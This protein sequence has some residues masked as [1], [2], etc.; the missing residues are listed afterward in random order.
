MLPSSYFGIQAPF[1]L[2]YLFYYIR[3]A[4]KH[5]REH[6]TNFEKQKMFHVKHHA[7]FTLYDS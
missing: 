5:M 6:M 7:Q 4:L 1:D 2:D 3:W